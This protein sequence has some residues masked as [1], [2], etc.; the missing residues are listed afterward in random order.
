[1]RGFY[2]C[3]ASSPTLRSTSLS[4][5]ISAASK[6]STPGSVSSSNRGVLGI[7]GSFGV[8]VARSLNSCCNRDGGFWIGAEFDTGKHT[9]MFNWQIDACRARRRFDVRTR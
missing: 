2:R 7:S 1:M 8:P 5:A 6:A 3:S 9:G 4:S